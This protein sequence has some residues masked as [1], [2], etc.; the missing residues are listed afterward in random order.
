MLHDLELLQEESEACHHK[1]EPHQGQT[2]ANPSQ[3]SPL[4]RQIIVEAGLLPG[5]CWPIHRLLLVPA[6]V[7]GDRDRTVAMVVAVAGLEIEA[8]PPLS[9]EQ[10][11]VGTK[12]LHDMRL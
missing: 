5:S 4:S 6:E 9:E 11:Q 2:S 1:S 8:G 3:K 7:M 10:A 12:F